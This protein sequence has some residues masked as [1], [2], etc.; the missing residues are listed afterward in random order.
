MGKS[1]VLLEDAVSPAV[2]VLKKLFSNQGEISD[3]DVSTARIAASLVSA[4]TRLLQTESA[5]EAVY[6]SMARDLAANPEQLAEYIKYSMPDVPL[7]TV[8]AKKVPQIEEKS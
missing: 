5:R 4:W 2:K 6:Y 1:S 8:L 3:V 7:A